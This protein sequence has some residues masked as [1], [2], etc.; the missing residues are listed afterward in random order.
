MIFG[1]IKVV[2]IIDSNLLTVDSPTANDAKPP[3]RVSYA[4]VIQ[5]KAGIQRLVQPAAVLDTG[6]RPPQADDG[7]HFHYRPA[8][9]DTQLNPRAVTSVNRLGSKVTDVTQ[10][11][12]GRSRHSPCA[13]R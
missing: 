12:R 6:L 11:E 2:A 8:P 9:M 1:V 4:F 10:A 3:S 7:G 5:A 13:C